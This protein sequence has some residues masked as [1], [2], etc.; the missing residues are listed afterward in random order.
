MKGRIA[1][2]I[3]LA[4]VGGAIAVDRVSPAAPA[5]PASVSLSPNAGVLSCPWLTESGGDAYLGLANVGAGQASVRV[6]IVPE[7][8]QPVDMS[9]TLPP[10]SAKLIR[11]PAAVTGRAAAFVEYS[12][13]AVVASHVLGLPGAQGPPASAAGTGAA[14][15]ERAGGADAVVTQATTANADATLTLFNPGSAEADVSITLIADGRV[16]QPLRLARRVVPSHARL[17]VRLGDYAFNAGSITVIT[18]ANAGRVVAEALLRSGAGVE[19]L[20][21]QTPSLDVVAIAGQSGAGS[22]VRVATVGQD[23]TGFDARLIGAQGQV[24][25]SGFPTSLPPFAA[26]AVQIPD[27]GRSGPAAYAFDASVGS[28]IVAGT[29]WASS[30]RGEVDYSSL[31]AVAVSSRWAAVFP[32]SQPAAVTDGIIVNPGVTAA[33]VRLTLIS[34]SGP[35]TQELTVPAGRLVVFNAGRG[36]GAFAVGLDSDTPVVLALRGSALSNRLVFGGTAL[37]GES[38]A[39]A[40]PVAVGIDPRAGVPAPLPTSR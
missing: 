7:K 39:A 30:K 17:D 36:S 1:F 21:G 14:A 38:L 34:P 22:V 9:A 5:R 25:A 35:V 37:L 31:P 40:S 18:H 32:A 6:G 15:C 12:G 8:G 3:F 10:G 29:S 20:P 26:R 19:L 4:L 33:N 2:A 27:Q 28:P 13:G 23:D 16:L 24:S 11:V